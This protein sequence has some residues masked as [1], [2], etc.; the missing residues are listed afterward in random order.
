MYLTFTDQGRIWIKQG[1]CPY[2]AFIFLNFITLT[3]FRA[4]Y[5]HPCIDEGEILHEELTAMPDF[6]HWQ[7]V[8]PLD[9]N[10]EI[11]L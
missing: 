1:I 8:L 6:T 7:N 5:P 10:S 9:E 11:N 4:R 2:G 3:V